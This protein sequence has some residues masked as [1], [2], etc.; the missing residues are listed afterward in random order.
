M[1]SWVFQTID[2]FIERPHMQLV[3][4]VHP[5]EIRG[6]PRSRQ[7][8]TEE[9][10]SRYPDLPAHIH[11]IGPDNPV[12][13]YALADKADVVLIYATKT[14]LELAARGI[15]V[16]VAGEGWMRNKGFSWDASSPSQYKSLLDKLPFGKRLEPAARERARRYAYHFF[17]RRM[18]PLRNVVE[19][20]GLWPPLRVK[21]DSFSELRQGQD[22]GLDVLCQGILEGGDFIYPAEAYANRG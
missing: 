17:L 19:R 14:G 1:L 18:I 8:I 15:P 12:S 11:V 13:A 10:F 21:V 22:P 7:Q 6:V 20:A 3:I 2:Y 9:I 5:A 4:R 16:I